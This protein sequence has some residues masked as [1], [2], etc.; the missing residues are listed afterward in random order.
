MKN[1]HNDNTP[2]AGL[3]AFLPNFYCADRKKI[4]RTMTWLTQRA[5]KRCR[6]IV[7]R[8]AEQGDVVKVSKFNDCE[9]KSIW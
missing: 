3:Q 5:L 8:C 4:H 6:K 1:L 7:D 2:K 9:L